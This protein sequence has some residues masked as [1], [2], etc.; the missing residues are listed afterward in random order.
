VTTCILLVED[1][2]GIQELV[3][4][5][6]SFVGFDVIQALNGQV[7]LTKADR[8]E[9]GLIYLDMHMPVM[10]GWHFLAVYHA[11]HGPEVPI[12]VVSAQTFDPRM[13]RRWRRS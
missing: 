6:L 5:P 11:T 13:I 1:E 10:G 7:A 12:I 8:Y 9:P 3:S 4:R 2:D